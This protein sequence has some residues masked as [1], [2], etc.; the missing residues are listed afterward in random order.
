MLLVLLVMFC[1]SINISSPPWW[2]GWNLHGSGG[3]WLV[4][5][6]L[7]LW[8]LMSVGSP[9]HLF[10]LPQLCQQVWIF[11]YGLCKYSIINGWIS[12]GL[13]WRRAQRC[14]SQPQ[15]PKDEHHTA[16]TASCHQFT[17]VKALLITWSATSWDVSKVWV[18]EFEQDFPPTATDGE[19]EKDREA[20]SSAAASSEQQSESRTCWWMLANGK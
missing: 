11:G 13:W 10:C 12:V 16:V 5:H 6:E 1:M 4:L 18:D 20:P 2:P 19:A 7:Q 8:F 14:S 9:G 3:S 17:M 15:Q